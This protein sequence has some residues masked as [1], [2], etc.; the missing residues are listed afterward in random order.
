VPREERATSS[1]SSNG[2]GRPISRSTAEVFVTAD[3]GRVQRDRVDCIQL[4][5][6]P[7]QVCAFDDGESPEW[8]S[9]AVW[10]A[11][12][13]PARPGELPRRHACGSADHARL[14]SL[15]SP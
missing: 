11:R 12:A 8:R 5:S 10:S 9:P 14:G 6:K 15:P 2:S 3:V 1:A 13:W 7:A 4:I